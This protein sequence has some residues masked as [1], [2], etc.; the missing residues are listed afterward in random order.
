MNPNPSHKKH[1]FIVITAVA[2]ILIA[3]VFTA[4]KPAKKEDS[5]NSAPE[6]QKPASTKVAERSSEDS[7]IPRGQARSSAPDPQ[8]KTAENELNSPSWSNDP[9]AAAP[10]IPPG[11]EVSKPEV[12]VNIDGEN[13]RPQFHGSFSERMSISTR[14]TATLAINWPVEHK[15]DEILAST[16]NDGTINGEA[17]AIL[18]RGKDGKFRLTFQAGEHSGATQVILRAANLAYTLNF[19]VPTGNANV[20]PPTLQ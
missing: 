8:S 12:A 17:G 11:V 9:P 16:L 18:K 1:T 20:D 4:Q 6:A 3:I 14:G 13:Q 5:A 10:V 2:V 15:A 7:P 19:W